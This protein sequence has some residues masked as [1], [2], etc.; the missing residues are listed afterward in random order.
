[1]VFLLCFH[2]KITALAIR[3]QIRGQISLQTYKKGVKSKWSQTQ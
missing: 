1:M 2:P 3:G